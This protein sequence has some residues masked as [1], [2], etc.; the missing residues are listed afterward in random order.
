MDEA[1]EK[2]IKN[3]TKKVTDLE[4]Q[5][6]QQKLEKNKYVTMEWLFPQLKASSYLYDS[7]KLKITITSIINLLLA[8]IAILIS[9]LR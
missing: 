3:L 6:Q 4:L 9:V 1:Q 2:I 8:A 7:L 5:I